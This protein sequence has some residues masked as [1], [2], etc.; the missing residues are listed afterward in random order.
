MKGDEMGASPRRTARRA[1]LVAAGVCLL[2]ALTTPTSPA[3]EDDTVPPPEVFRGA[4]SAQALSVQVDRDA[5]LPVP[6]LFRFIALDGSSIYES[7]TRQARASLLFPGNGLI[8]GPSLL[9]GTFGGAFPP[10]F[11][12][13]LDTCLQYKYPLTVFADDF[14]PD[15]ASSGSVALGSPTDPVSGTA[16][17][18][19]AHAGEDSATTDAAMQDL[20]VLGLPAL[21]SVTPLL[22]ALGVATPDTS[23][24]TMESAASRTR[25]R[26]VQGGL[27]VDS[28][29]TI[30]GLRLLGG[31]VRVG[32]IRSEA[33]ITDDAHG[34]RTA[35]ADL[36]VSGVTVGGVPAQIT[37]DGLVLGTPTGGLGPLVQQLQAQLNDLLRSLN[38]KVTQ[39]SSEESTDDD[40][41][42]V[43]RTGGLLI[44][45]SV[46]VDGLG[47]VPGP[48]GDIDPNG[49]YV[50]SIQVGAT[51]A[52]G[53]A[54]T[55][56][57]DAVVPETPVA[58]GGFD[59]GSLP[60][61]D[62]GEAVD[63]PLP[64]VPDAPDAP[65][66]ATP[67]APTDGTLVHSVVD[68]F[69][70]RLGLVYLALMFAVLGL[71]IL[72]SFT[73]A[74]LPGPRP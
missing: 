39:L 41:F 47:T 7:S 70:D 74:R 44:E 10:E 11:K 57:P 56:D 37:E 4:A 19:V 12:P 3:Q 16:V 42:A 13:V 2:L 66:V 32:S 52:R 53:A 6:D 35:T 45:V 30:S 49:V 71:C 20:R 68:L 61:F 21:G 65:A 46:P 29:A 8:L 9:C 64:A 34:K 36:E 27:V 63:F 58:D 40:G 26:I 24:V 14:A 43:A 67:D 38:I 55:F 23:L 18:A 50:A 28:E 62:G 54:F 17:R 1:C 15:G 60:T 5:L 72:P 31:L 25:Q 33:H 69:G 59:P 73:P 51:A 22:T 48:L